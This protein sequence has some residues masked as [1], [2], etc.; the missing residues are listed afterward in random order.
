MGI[1]KAKHFING[2]EV[3]PLNFDTIGFKIDYSQDYNLPELNTDSIIFVKEDMKLIMNHIN[4]NGVFQGIPYTITFGTTT[5]NY[6]IDLTEAPQIKDSQIEV[7]IVRLKSVMSFMSRANGLSFEAL[8][9]T[10]PINLVDA[11]YIIVKDNQGMQLVM[12]SINTFVLAK[13]LQESILKV[14]ESV[15]D[16]IRA[17]TFNPLPP[18]GDILAL[19]VL[20][21]ARLAYA[22]LITIQIINMI[23]EMINILVPFKKIF[24]ASQVIE[25]INKGCTKLGYTFTSSLIESNLTILPIPLS[26]S[27]PSVFEKFNALDN[28]TYTKGYPTALDSTPTLGS[29]IDFLKTFYNADLSVNGNTVSLEPYSQVPSIQIDNTLNIQSEREDGYTFNTGESWKRYLI[30][31]QF[32]TSDLHTLNNYQKAQAEYSTESNNSNDPDY[33][34]IKGLVRVDIP[35]AY[36]IRKDKLNYVE[37]KLL[38]LAEFADTV[39]SAVGGNGQFASKVNGNKGH[40]Q[41]S[42]QQFGVTKLLYLTG[43]KQPADYL[44]KIGAKAIFNYHE[45]NNVKENFKRIYTSSIPLSSHQFNQIINGG[46]VVQDSITDEILE[47]ISIDWIN[48]NVTAEINYSVKSTEGF[49]TKTIEIY[50]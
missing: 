43:K 13:E 40:I 1:L 32:D 5:L 11:S 8:N 7:K 20:L 23:A 6:Q 12:F 21:I 41:I 46:N 37:S 26:N 33:E 30:K 42:Q 22:T 45:S 35:F 17:V 27:S 31:Y 44:D 47:I 15:A 14:A 39:V 29:L 28:S 36:G 3:K 25:L 9:R 24:K 4:T 49:N 16:F 18:L 10:N 48:E 38:S 2:T 19:A 34:N 50:G